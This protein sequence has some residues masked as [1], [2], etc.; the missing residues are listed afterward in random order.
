MKKILKTPKTWQE[1]LMAMITR[2]AREWKHPSPAYGK[3]EIE[4]AT[5]HL[6]ATRSDEWAKSMPLLEQCKDAEWFMDREREKKSWYKEVGGLIEQ[7]VDTHYSELSGMYKMYLTS[8]DLLDKFW[9]IERMHSKLRPAAEV[10][11]SI[12]DYEKKRKAWGKRHSAI[13]A[14]VCALKAQLAF[15]EAMEYPPKDCVNDTRKSL[16]DLEDVLR[17]S[18]AAQPD[19]TVRCGRPGPRSG[20]SSR[21]LDR[22]SAA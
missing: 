2:R 19:L 22:P 16:S 12:L 13:H 18:M 14:G 8:D 17:E 7:Y 4:A 10:L 5:L 15:L 9:P 20:G 1:T 11:K 3:E 6:A 21:G